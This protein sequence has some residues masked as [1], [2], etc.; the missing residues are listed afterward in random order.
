M[1]CPLCHRH[2]AKARQVDKMEELE[3]NILH[4]D[5]T[6]QCHE[7]GGVFNTFAEYKLLRERL[8]VVDTTAET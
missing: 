7:C 1:E 2:G 4:I 8:S 6:I 3:D 5:F